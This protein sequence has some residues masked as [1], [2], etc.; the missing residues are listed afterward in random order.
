[1]DGDKSTCC[2]AVGAISNIVVKVTS[3]IALKGVS[4]A[5]MDTDA[6]KADFAEGV[7]SKINGVSASDIKNIVATEIFTDMAPPQRG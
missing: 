7:A 4:K 2:K 3:S 1:M 5:A 6:A